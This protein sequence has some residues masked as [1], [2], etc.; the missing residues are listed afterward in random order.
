[1]LRNNWFELHE[2]E[3]QMNSSIGARVINQIT[4]SMDIQK[5]KF[6]RGA[7]RSNLLIAFTSRTI[8]SLYTFSKNSK[9]KKASLQILFH[10]F[11]K[12]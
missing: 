7:K 10:I 2:K 9:I 6:N 8:F 11:I 1:M 5:K 12:I 3:Y 4:N